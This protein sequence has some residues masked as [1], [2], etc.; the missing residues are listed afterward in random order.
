MQQMNQPY[1][2]DPYGSAGYGSTDGDFLEDI[3]F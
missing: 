1:A 3:P 2:A